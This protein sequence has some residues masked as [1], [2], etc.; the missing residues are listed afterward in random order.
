MW[1]NS[2]RAELSEFLQNRKQYALNDDDDDADIILCTEFKYSAH[3]GQLMIGEIFIQIYNEQ[4][5]F[6]IEA[7]LS[8]F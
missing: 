2:T 1:D 8:I 7:S 3:E 4:P 5:T 6:P